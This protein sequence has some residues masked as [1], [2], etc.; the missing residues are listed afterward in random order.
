SGFLAVDEPTLPDWPGG[1]GPSLG[2]AVARRVARLHGGRVEL[3]AGSQGGC[4]L[5]LMLPTGD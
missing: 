3:N 4:S 2:L 5:T 1:H